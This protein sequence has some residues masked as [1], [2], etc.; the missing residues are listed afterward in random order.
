MDLGIDDWLHMANATPPV[1]YAQPGL[2]L[3]VTQGRSHGFWRVVE[4]VQTVGERVVAAVSRRL[5]RSRLLRES[6]FVLGVL[7]LIALAWFGS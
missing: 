3:G 2:D 4:K 1:G 7:A 6:V 5:D